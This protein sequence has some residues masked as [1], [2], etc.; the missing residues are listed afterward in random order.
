MWPNGKRPEALW[1]ARGGGETC[2]ARVR[3]AVQVRQNVVGALMGA[4]EL[5]GPARTGS[6]APA[7]R[8]VGASE[9]ATVAHTKR[10]GTRMGSGR[11]RGWNRIHVQTSAQLSSSWPVA[12]RRGR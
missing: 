7:L 4:A 11:V 2:G 6:G 10:T 12:R 5:K 1:R 9:F 3:Q 8:N